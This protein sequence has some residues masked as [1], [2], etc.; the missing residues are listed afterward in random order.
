[1]L[2][3]YLRRALAR[4]PGREAEAHPDIFRGVQLPGLASPRP[5]RREDHRDAWGGPPRREDGP[6]RLL[7]PGGSGR[8]G[9][10]LPRPRRGLRGRP[11]HRRRG[12]PPWRGNVYESPEELAE[13]AAREFA[14]RAAEAIRDRGRF[15]VVLAGG[16]TP[17]T[18]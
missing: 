10:G 18:T 3:R 14:S 8:G 1:S 6:H 2:R 7:R 16:S 12:T 9:D 4:L 5:L 11:E 13:G 15:A 17:K